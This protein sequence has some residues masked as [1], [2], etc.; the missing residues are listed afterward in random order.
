MALSCFAGAA[1]LQSD[2]LG[3][4]PAM[5]GF[6]PSGAAQERD[7]EQ[8]FDAQLSAA[9]MRGWLQ[10]LASAPN[11]VGSPHDKAN[12][13]FLLA[14]FKKWG[15][16]AHMEIFDVQEVVTEREAAQQQQKL[17]SSD[18]Y[19]LA[20][21]PT[22]PLAPPERLSN[23]PDIDLAPLDEAAKRLRHS[24]L[25]YEAAYDARAA[26]GLAIPAG[27]LR[28]INALMATMEQRTLDEGGLPG[29]PWYRNM[30]QAPGALTGYAAKTLPGVQEALE[31]RQWQLAE[32]YAVITAK[33]LENYRGQLDRL[34]VLLGQGHS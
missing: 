3:A 23:V 17:F 8:R 4:G 16:D 1:L 34:T 31:A 15:W 21:D 30:I 9:E 28:E 19:R 13:E 18:A 11:Q 25:A 27:R 26:G 24:A 6:A 22:H 32:Q 7:L 10:Q 20:A 2:V 29:R 14:Q 12:A 5:L 33:A